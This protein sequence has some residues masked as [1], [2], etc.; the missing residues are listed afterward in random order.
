MVPNNSRFFPGAQGKGQDP[1]SHRLTLWAGSACS[2]PLRAA[3]EEGRM[4]TETDLPGEA[5]PGFLS[6]TQRGSSVSYQSLIS[7]LQKL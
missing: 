1:A 7:I 2:R 3:E 5:D 6:F 4:A